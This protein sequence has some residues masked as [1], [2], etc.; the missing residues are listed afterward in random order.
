MGSEYG[1]KGD[2]CDVHQSVMMQFQDQP[3][4]LA[5]VRCDGATAFGISQPMA[6]A[7]RMGRLMMH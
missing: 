1:G 3:S 5:A 4:A 6:D 7:E 2:E